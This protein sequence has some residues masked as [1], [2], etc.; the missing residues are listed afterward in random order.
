MYLNQYLKLKINRL[1]KFSRES[2]SS[3]VNHIWV[4]SSAA[5][6]TQQQMHLLFDKFIF[7]YLSLAVLYCTYF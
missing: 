2:I 7:L 6:V 5:N 1:Q 3:F 4:A